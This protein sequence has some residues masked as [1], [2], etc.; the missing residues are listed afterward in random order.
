[1][2]TKKELKQRYKEMKTPMGLIMIRNKINGKTF[3][4]ASTD[5]KSLIN[6]YKFELQM[7]GHKI[8]SLQREWKEY[9]EDSFEFRVLEELEY[10]EG[11]DKKDYT[12]ELEIMKYIWMER[13]SKDKE[14]ELY[15]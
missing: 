10:E 2:A 7:G 13:L 5:T 9:G 12:E 6:R 15:K 3:L 8:K 14:L 11:D 4:E 1:M